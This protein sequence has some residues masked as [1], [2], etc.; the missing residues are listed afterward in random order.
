MIWNKSNLGTIFFLLPPLSSKSFSFPQ[1]VCQNKHSQTIKTQIV[2]NLSFSIPHYSGGSYVVTLT[3]VTQLY[4][5]IPYLY[6]AR[7]PPPPFIFYMHGILPVHTGPTCSLTL[8]FSCSQHVG[9]PSPRPLWCMSCIAPS[10]LETLSFGALTCRFGA[11]NISWHSLQSSLLWL[12][13]ITHMM[14]TICLLSIGPGLV[15]SLLSFY[16]PSSQL[17]LGFHSLCK[18]GHDTAGICYQLCHTSCHRHPGTSEFRVISAALKSILI[19][20][21]SNYD[22]L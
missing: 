17:L 6:K 20:K 21:N 16:S 4:L 8:V 2:P 19:L 1:Y 18:S 5:F 11:F 7:L 12:Y 15:F 9:R 10:L 22:L 14:K 3:V 13:I